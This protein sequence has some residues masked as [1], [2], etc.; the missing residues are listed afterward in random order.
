MDK[1][2]TKVRGWSDA[3]KAE[4]NRK[5]ATSSK[6]RASQSKGEMSKKK[7]TMTAKKERNRDS[8]KDAMEEMY[9]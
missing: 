6:G 7:P 3:D 8:R 5:A 2:S 9:F 1:S 4:K